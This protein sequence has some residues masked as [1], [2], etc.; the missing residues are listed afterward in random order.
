MAVNDS[1]D[2]QDYLRLLK[3]KPEESK[4]LFKEFLI[5]VTRFFREDK[6]GDFGRQVALEKEKYSWDRMAEALE[7][8]AERRGK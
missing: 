6:A 7:E 4:S 2:I 3:E 1:T 5:S 8:L